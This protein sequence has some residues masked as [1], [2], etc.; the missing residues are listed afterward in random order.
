MTERYSHPS[1]F[2]VGENDVGTRGMR[3]VRLEIGEDGL[4]NLPLRPVAPASGVDGRE[5]ASVRTGGGAGAPR[6]VVFRALLEWIYTDHTSLALYFCGELGQLA[7]AVGLPRLYDECARRVL[8]GGAGRAESSM[9]G[10]TTS[11]WSRPGGDERGG[12]GSGG[13]GGG[14]GGG[15]T[16]TGSTF[17]R[18]MLQLVDAPWNFADV[19]VR[20]HD[21]VVHAHR[22]VLWARCPYFRAIFEQPLFAES[23]QAQID[24]SDSD[25]SAAVFVDLMRFVYAGDRSVITVETAC[26]LCE[27]A[28]FFLVFDL[29]QL[30]ESV[31][32]QDVD[33]DIDAESLANLTDFADGIGARRLLKR[34]NEL[35]AATAERV[36]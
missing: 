32:I 19:S 23:Q 29:R 6:A 14:G 15:G 22:D 4:Y 33:A 8:G 11:T 28:S 30:A 13:G 25:F 34:C 20:F 18:D 2:R 10:S 21:G 27:A 26:D 12:G 35:A 31:L 16:F 9:D 24:M 5:G 36:V 17:T 3:D 1:L 7:L